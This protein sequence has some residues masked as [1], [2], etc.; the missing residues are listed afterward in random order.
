[1]AINNQLYGWLL[2]LDGGDLWFLVADLAVGFGSSCW[3]RLSVV[4]AS[5]ELALPVFD[6]VHDLISASTCSLH[7][8]ITLDVELRIVVN[9][10]R[11]VVLVLDL[12]VDVVRSS[13]LEA[14]TAHVLARVLL[15]YDVVDWMASPDVARAK[16]H[17]ID[18]A[19]SEV[20]LVRATSA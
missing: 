5:S 16:V 9:M 1:M 20:V 3:D 13:N 6:G 4:S 10:V 15:A 8:V 17:W 2:A 19:S 11:I 12:V 7:V 18:E 14:L